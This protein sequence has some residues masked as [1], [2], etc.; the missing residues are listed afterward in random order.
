MVREMVNNE[1][2]VSSSWRESHSLDEL[3]DFFALDI[4]LRVV[5][6]TP[7]IWETRRASR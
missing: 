1:I 4:R 2:V 6:V 7:D 3:R 5:G